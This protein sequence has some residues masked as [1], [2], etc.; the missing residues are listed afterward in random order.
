[1]KRELTIAHA[2]GFCKNCFDRRRHGSAYCGGCEGKEPR[3]KVYQDSVKN[4]PLLK[5]VV[6]RFG[7]SKEQLRSI[8]FTYGDTIYC[9]MPL[10]YALQAHELTHVFRQEQYGV[11][12]WWDRYMKDDKFRLD[13]ELEA[14][15]VQYEVMKIHDVNVFS[16]PKAEMAAVK[17]AQDLSSKMYGE[18]IDEDKALEL[19]KSV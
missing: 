9:D 11:K 15:M 14:Y 1:M 16:P 7:L 3:K 12:E 19:I 4:F 5:K 18:I 8:I 13:Q 6:K 2:V 17:M 10:S